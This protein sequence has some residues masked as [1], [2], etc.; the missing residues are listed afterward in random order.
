MFVIYTYKTPKLF[1]MNL[2]LAFAELFEG[3]VAVATLGCVHVGISYGLLFSHVTILEME[4]R[5]K[6]FEEGRIVRKSENHI[7]KSDPWPRWQIWP[8]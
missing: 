3:V 4:E 6:A 8:K 5:R 1:F 2:L 7:D